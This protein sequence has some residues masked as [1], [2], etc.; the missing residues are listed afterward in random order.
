MDVRDSWGQSPIKR[1]KHYVGGWAVGI[2]A[3]GVT[4]QFGAEFCNPEDAV[5]LGNPRL[6]SVSIRWEN[7]TFGGTD[8]FYTDGVSLSVAHTGR[9]WL[10]PI[11]DRLP[12][13]LA[14]GRRTVSY[15]F[16]Q[17]MCTPSDIN[18]PVP[19]P[20]D[21][22][23]AGILYASVSFHFEHDNVYNG[24]KLVTGVVGPWS[25]AEE[26]QREVHRLVGAGV[27]QGWDYQLHNEP[28]VNLVLERRWKYQLLGSS[29][30]FSFETIPA[31]DVMLGNV[32]TQGQVGMQCRAGW[33]VPSD[34]GHTLMRGMVH[35]PPPCRSVKW[36][37]YGMAGVY[38][39][40]VLHNITL[41]GNTWC[42][43]PSVE[44]EYFVPAAEIGMG[45][46][47]KRWQV[48]FTYVFWGKEF[49]GQPDYTKFG[50]L[51]CSYLF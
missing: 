38:G 35:L 14:K 32:L 49:R 18:I 30:G 17:I 28:V 51:T 1:L 33:R 21:R 16:G 31:V 27:P 45:V 5:S 26:T 12:G 39:M 24:V 22:P 43:S 6:W 42:S 41:D 40:V 50:A 47:I 15:E 7:D 36:G 46:S 4:N 23:Y 20:N 48:A 37:V 13:W 2:V 11:A 34:F 44:K 29:E 19:D 10:D 9:S 8:R 25:F 3:V